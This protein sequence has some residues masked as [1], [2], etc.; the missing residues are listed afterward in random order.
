MLLTLFSFPCFIHCWSTAVAAAM[1]TLFLLL[2][3]SYRAL[4]HHKTCLYMCNNG[5]WTFCISTVIWT[6]ATRASTPL[7]RL[8][9]T[10]SKSSWRDWGKQQFVV[11][12]EKS[13]HIAITQLLKTMFLTPTHLV[14][15]NHT[16][17][18][19]LKSRLKLKPWGPNFSLFRFQPGL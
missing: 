19:Y 11:Y 14:P 13:N 6:V 5:Y 15:H 1:L 2:C 10:L 7:V 17:F 3:G 12:I 16:Q 4:E 18:W 8:Y 9:V